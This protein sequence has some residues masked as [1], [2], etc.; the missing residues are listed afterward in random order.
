MEEE[1]KELKE[2]SMGD[3]DNGIPGMV[4]PRDPLKFRK[5]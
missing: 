3:Q 5:N 2:G 4:F 1:K